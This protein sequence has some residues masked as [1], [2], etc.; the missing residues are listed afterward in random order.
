MVREKDTKDGGINR[1]TIKA[2]N[3]SISAGS[4]VLRLRSRISVPVVIERFG[5][6]SS[7]DVKTP[8]V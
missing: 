7:R 8:S 5:H 3:E 1:K 4:K 2:V 6:A